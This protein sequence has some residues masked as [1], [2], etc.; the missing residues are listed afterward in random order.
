MVSQLTFV[1]PLNRRE[2]AESEIMD[3]DRYLVRNNLGRANVHEAWKSHNTKRSAMESAPSRADYLQSE[4]RNVLVALFDSR[5]QRKSKAEARM[6][7]ESELFRDQ[8]ER[9]RGY[10]QQDGMTMIDDDM[11][12]GMRGGPIGGGLGG[13]GGGGGPSRVPNLHDRPNA[14]DAFPTLQSV[15]P[16]SELPSLPDAPPGVQRGMSLSAIANLVKPTNEDELDRMKRAR[17]ASLRKAA[18]NRMGFMGDTD[19]MDALMPVADRAGDYEAIAGAPPAAAAAAATEGQIERNKR[20]AAAF[21]IQPSTVRPLADS[22]KFYGTDGKG[23]GIFE[24]DD[25]YKIELEVGK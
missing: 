13:G 8:F 22:G 14:L 4:A 3:L 24:E 18:M 5:K 20:F 17:T 12:P 16:V 6:E 2:L 1:D 25:P 19:A 23:G 9:Q 11:N 10:Q 21:G 7:R 15:T